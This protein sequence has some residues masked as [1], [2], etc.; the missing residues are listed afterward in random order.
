[1]VHHVLQRL[2]DVGTARHLFLLRVTY[3][4]HFDVLFSYLWGHKLVVLGCLIVFCC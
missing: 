4:N 3:R 1:M 2:R